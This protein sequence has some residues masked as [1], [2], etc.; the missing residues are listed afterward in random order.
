MILKTC[1]VYVSTYTR[2]FGLLLF[3]YFS[4]FF[5]LTLFYADHVPSYTRSLVD[6]LTSLPLPP[7]VTI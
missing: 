5:W 4:L 2:V 6:L 1:E 3:I 7:L